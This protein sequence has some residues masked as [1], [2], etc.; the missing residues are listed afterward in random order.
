ME[1]TTFYT[2]SSVLDNRSRERAVD[3]EAFYK[4]IDR[5]MP[6]LDT[7]SNMF[8]Q[9]RIHING[10]EDD[11]LNNTSIHFN[12]NEQLS[13]EYLAHK[14]V[15]YMHNMQWDYEDRNR[16]PD[17]YKVGYYYS[18]DPISKFMHVI[19]LSLVREIAPEDMAYMITNISTF[20]SKRCEHMKALTD[21]IIDLSASHVIETRRATSSTGVVEIIDI[22]WRSPYTPME[23]TPAPAFMREE[24]WKLWWKTYFNALEFHANHSVKPQYRTPHIPQIS[25]EAL[26]AFLAQ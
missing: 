5:S 25:E 17:Y 24:Q 3:W 8:T 21:V 12:I 26:A 2:L 13:S 20:D 16:T 15:N 22:E 6:S 19:M 14:L 9:I 23:F 11:I 7:S 4:L 1:N 18:E 10:N